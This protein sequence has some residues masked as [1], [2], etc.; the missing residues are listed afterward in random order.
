MS[1]K[2]IVNTITDKIQEKSG[3][4]MLVTL[5]VVL[6]IVLVVLQI[7]P[8]V[9]SGVATAV[10]IPATGPGSEWN[11]TV[12]PALVTASGV[13][14]AVGGLYKVTIMVAIIS[15]LIGMLYT[16][17]GSRQTGTGGV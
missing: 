15:I 3:V 14:E 7:I 1:L 6:L 11:A 2:N 4:M 10:V 5:G 16:V 13:W 17:T 9:N 12:N 8:L